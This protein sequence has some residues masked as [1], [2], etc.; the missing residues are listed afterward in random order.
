M[1][2]ILQDLTH[3][4]SLPLVLGEDQE[5]SLCELRAVAAMAAYAGLSGATLK[6]TWKGLQ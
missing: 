6:M 5:A 4:L 1:Q 3:G 2:R